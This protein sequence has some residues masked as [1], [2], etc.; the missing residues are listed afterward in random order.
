[1]SRQ[2][3]PIIAMCYDF[4]GT[5]SP[6]NMQE[7][8]YIPQ[9][10]LKPKQFWAEAK[11]RAKEQKA[12]EILSYMC[13][14]L[15]KS[16][17]SKKVKVTKEAFEKCGNTVE[18]FP[19]VP[20]WF[21]RV[22]EYCGKKGISVEHFIISSGIKEMI[23]GTTIAKEFKSIFASSFMYDQ[24]GVADWPG[25]AINYTTKTQ[26]LFRINKGLLDAW[27]NSKI[28]KYTPK[29]KRR[30]PFERMIYIGDG[31]TDIPCMKLVK[32]QGGFSI[33]VYRSYSSRKKAEAKKLLQEGRVD[34]SCQADFRKGTAIDEQVKLVINKMVADYNLLGK[35]NDRGQR[36]A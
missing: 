15:E 14:M 5:L 24:H 10:D 18:L 11:E 27:D 16:R 33:A 4:D 31:A 36:V 1:M 3:R 9:L 13:L 12:D 29:H 30:I 8:E 28:N 7:Y 26:F 35:A 25:L 6:R 17:N 22:N 20:T 21:K 23:A 19:G 32:E 34:F 2:P